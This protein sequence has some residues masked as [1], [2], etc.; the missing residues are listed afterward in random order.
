MTVKI[1]WE[2]IE[3]LEGNS[4]TGYVPDPKNSKS[5]VTIASGFDIG[6]RSAQE[7]KME[8]SRSVASKL[9][10]YIGLIGQQAL[11]A[12][13]KKPLIVSPRE[14]EEINLY[15]HSGALK[16]LLASWP[17]SAYKKFEELEEEFQTVI[18]SV[19]FQYG[20]LQKRTPKFWSQVTSGKWHE[21][22]DNLRDFGDGYKTR[23]NREADLLASRLYK[24]FTKK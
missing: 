15:A 1:N 22:I 17:E 3:S 19:S 24:T 6:Q 10:P 2:F 18:A 12:L 8:L 16:K 23:R 14:A 9:L 7:I 20:D 21:A 5:G 13:E 4:L 11:Q